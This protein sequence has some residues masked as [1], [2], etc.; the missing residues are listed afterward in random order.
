MSKKHIVNCIIRKAH[1][2]PYERIQGIGGKTILGKKWT[3]SEAEAIERIKRGELFFVVVDKD[4]VRI[5][6]GERKGRK[7]LKTKEDTDKKNNLLEL[8]D[9]QRRIKLVP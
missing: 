9:C 5:I 3:L 1:K 4:P 8:P 7:Y 6:I 2:N